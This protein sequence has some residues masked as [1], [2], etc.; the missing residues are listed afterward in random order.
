MVRGEQIKLSSINNPILPFSLGSA[1]I[2]THKHSFIKYINLDKFDEPL[3]EIK[4]NLKSMLLPT[5][6]ENELYPQLNRV[7][8]HLEYLLKQTELK[9]TNVKPLKNV[10]N[11]RGLLNIVGKGYKWAFGVLDSDDAERYDNAISTLENNQKT[12]H[13]DLENYLTISKQFMNESLTTFSKIIENQN[14]INKQIKTLESN[15]NKFTFFLRMQNYLDMMIIDCQNLITILDN[16]QNSILF[17]N[18]ETVHNLILPLNELKQL[19]DLMNSLYMGSLPQFENTQSYYN[20]IKVEVHYSQNNI[21]FI[22][23]FPILRE[24]LYNYYHLYPIPIKNQTLIP[25]KPFIIL[26]STYHHYEDNP[27]PM[28]EDTCIY[29]VTQQVSQ[30]DCIPKVL[31]GNSNQSCRTTDVYIER[32]IVEPIN[33]AYIIIIPATKITIEKQCNEHGYEEIALPQ[34]IHLPQHCSVS[35]NGYTYDNSMSQTQETPLELLPVKMEQPNPTDAQWTPIQK[36]SMDRLTD[37]KKLA[38]KTQL[39]KLQTLQK[40]NTNNIVLY[41][42]ILLILVTI[43]FIIFKLVIKN[44]VKIIKYLTTHK[45]Q[46]DEIQKTSDSNNPTLLFSS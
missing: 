8:E 9:L 6:T 34:L 13:H 18:L 26:N 4:M 43:L 2:T 38:E 11:K 24:N 5:Q 14:L 10:R 22:F 3:K 27:C 1:R 45:K 25:P 36:V 32:D 7:R 15:L 37:I 23:H 35:I 28:I 30:N 42:C 29:H 33:D 39:H 31:L 41:I 19:I 44:K 12:L 40:D 17:A 20:L 21:C 16:I 46:E